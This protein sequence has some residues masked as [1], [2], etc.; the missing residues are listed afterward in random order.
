M[1][2]AGRGVK[3]VGKFVKNTGKYLRRKMGLHNKNDGD[4]SKESN[5]P[6]LFIR[7]IDDIFIERLPYL[8]EEQNTYLIELLTPENYLLRRD[9]ES[10][11]L[12]FNT[13]DYLDP[14]DFDKIL[15]P[16]MK[17]E[18]RKSVCLFKSTLPTLPERPSKNRPK[19]KDPFILGEG[20]FGRV[21]LG[22]FGDYNNSETNKSVTAVKIIKG[23][24][25]DAAAGTAAG[26][27]GDADEIREKNALKNEI[28]ILESINHDENPNIVK[29]FTS[30]NE[31]APQLIFL[32]NF[33][34]V[35]WIHGYHKVLRMIKSLEYV[36]LTIYP[37]IW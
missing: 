24:G 32:L 17:D 10:E 20:N 29:Y 12:N 35:V 30:L 11:Y 28:E 31:L 36:C 18:T 7:E 21:V 15:I 34:D 3:K 22:V 6:N 1:I 26:A 16:V 37:I 14:S 9:G 19:V 2:L 33:L 13:H 5:I 25:G 8:E 23:T 27:G 4:D